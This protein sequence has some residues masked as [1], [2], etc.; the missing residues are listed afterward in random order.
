MSNTRDIEIRIKATDDAS[1]TIKRVA[2]NA[3]AAADKVGKANGRPS[4]PEPSVFKQIGEAGK[5]Q[6]LNDIG[7]IIDKTNNLS[8]AAGAIAKGFGAMLIAR[9]NAI[10]PINTIL[11]GRS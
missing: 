11:I 10:M 2:D 1:P 5:S 7:E 8:G 9:I 3:V 4:R 6:G